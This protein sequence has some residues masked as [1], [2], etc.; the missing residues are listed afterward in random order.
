[1]LNTVLFSNLI[2]WWL[3]THCVSILRSFHLWTLKQSG[4]GVSSQL[5]LEILGPDVWISS[6]GGVWRDEPK[7][8][9]VDCKCWKA[10]GTHSNSRTSARESGFHS[11]CL[12]CTEQNKIS[13]TITL[14]GVKRLTFQGLKTQAQFLTSLISR[15]R[16]L[17]RESFPRHCFE[18][19]LSPLTYF[20][21]SPLPATSY[22]LVPS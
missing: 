9:K 18:L 19:N 14:V 3:S 4:E 10:L 1:M 6:F 20:P 12:L 15:K 22:V 13:N 16:A 8:F 5:P 17:D 7:I 2:K 11:V 21:L